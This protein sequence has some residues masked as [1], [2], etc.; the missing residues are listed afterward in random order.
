MQGSSTLAQALCFRVGGVP[1][2]STCILEVMKRP[3]VSAV[4]LFTLALPAQEKGA[5]R[6]ASK[7]A[8]S[9][10]GDIILSPER[11]SI[12]FINVTIAKIRSIKP[13]EAPAAFSDGTPSPGGSGNLYRLSI[14]GNKRFAGKNTLCGAEDTQW[15]ITYVSGKTLQLAFY[16]GDTMP[17]LTPEAI[18]TAT[19]LCGTYTYVR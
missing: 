5:W 11:I 10:T 17:V 2:T 16:S 9:V 6:A 18:A 15:M 1:L 14:A 12:N 3:L 13:E 19:N 4:L 8:R 7:T